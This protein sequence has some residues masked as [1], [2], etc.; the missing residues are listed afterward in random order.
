MR[1]LYE[2]V[3]EN[4]MIYNC[5]EHS[6]SVLSAGYVA[7]VVW[8]CYVEIKYNLL[9]RAPLIY[10]AVH[11]V[12]YALFNLSKTASVVQWSEFLATDTEV[13]GSILGATR[14]SE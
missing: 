13:S 6:T 1:T 2:E 8:K 12:I 11:S 4:H 10:S 14:F 5:Y 3:S 7:G 9:R